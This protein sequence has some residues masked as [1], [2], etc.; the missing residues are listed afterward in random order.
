MHC[1]SESFPCIVNSGVPQG[2]KL[3]PLFFILYINDLCTTVIHSRCLL[4]TD[5]V[6][7]YKE[8]NNEEDAMKLQE[9]INMVYNW[10]VDNDLR[11]NI[12]MC[13]FLLHNH[14]KI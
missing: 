5:D 1:Q 14:N 3:S 10:S 9:D 13:H 2:S 11:F 6:K 8:I 7:L 12:K 4:Y